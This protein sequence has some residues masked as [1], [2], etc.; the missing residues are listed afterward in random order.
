MS[1]SLSAQ[2][3]P[4]SFD[5]GTSVVIGLI[6]FAVS[7]VVAPI[8]TA[9]LIRLGYRYRSRSGSFFCPHGKFSLHRTGRRDDQI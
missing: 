4:G 3:P 1:D 5:R 2:S 7:L 8:V 6:V 9:M